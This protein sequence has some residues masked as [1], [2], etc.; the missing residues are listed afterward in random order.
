MWEGRNRSESARR[1]RDHAGPPSLRAFAPLVRSSSCSSRSRSGRTRHCSQCLDNNSGL[2]CASADAADYWGRF[3][4]PRGTGAV[5]RGDLHGVKSR[6]WQRE[7]LRRLR[8]RES[9]TRAFSFFFDPEETWADADLP[10]S[11]ADRTIGVATHFQTGDGF[12]SS[13]PST[14]SAGQPRTKGGGKSCLRA[15]HGAAL[16]RR[17]GRAAQ[18]S[19]ARPRQPR[20]SKLSLRD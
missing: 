13:T 7:E 10:S 6:A 20:R 2:E 19:S 9:R 12:G 4:G 15:A 3:F 14:C 18:T 1:A 16:R 11:S 17:R 5:R 8:Q